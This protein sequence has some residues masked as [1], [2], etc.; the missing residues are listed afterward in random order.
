MGGCLAGNKKTNIRA[1]SSLERAHESFT[2]ATYA[3]SYREPWGLRFLA[4]TSRTECDVNLRGL[5]VFAGFIPQ[6]L[7][8]EKR[9]NPSY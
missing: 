7:H 4:S 3:S 8:Q 9:L 2:L 1:K 5:R 6:D